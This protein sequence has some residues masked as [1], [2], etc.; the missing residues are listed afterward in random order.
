MWTRRWLRLASSSLVVLAIALPVL[1]CGAR[2]GAVPVAPRCPDVADDAAV[3]AYDWTA[4][5]VD[6]ARAAD[7]KRALAAAIEVKRLAARVDAD[8][9]TGCGGLATDLGASGDFESGKEACEA[10]SRAIR[11]TIA[12]LGGPKI[13]LDAAA[14]KCGAP[15]DVFAVCA[16]ECEAR[17]RAAPTCEAG[18]L[19]GACT[20]ACSGACDVQSGA[21]CA[22][23]CRG[24][25]DGKCQGRCEGIASR[26]VCAGT[27]DGV[28][29]GA[30]TGAC[31]LRDKAPCNGTCTGACDAEMKTPRCVA[32]LASP[33][34]AC[35]AR[36]NARSFA[37]AD[38]TRAR[39]GVTIEA[40]D[41]PLA[42]KLTSALENDLPLVLQISSGMR[43]RLEKLAADAKALLADAEALADSPALGKCVAPTMREGIAACTSIQ[44]SLAAAAAISSSMP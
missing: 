24:K 25:C 28:C 36:C 29:T 32:A 12:K 27:C 42:K 22:G 8:L 41:K 2:P 6:A 19:Q 44:S 13:A 20:G 15:L 21:K 30:C 23:T 43:Q 16:A 37:K 9:K 14:P 39:V 5:H 1:D 40:S 17:E 34:A 26:G 33:S 38:C 31:D 11:E 7:L 3:L 4:F 10:A 35:A 18:K